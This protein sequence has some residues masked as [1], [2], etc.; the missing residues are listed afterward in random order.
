[1]ASVRGHRAAESPSPIM[2]FDLDSKLKGFRSH[3]F[4]QVAH[5]P[6]R[7]S[8]AFR[9]DRSV[10][11]EMA[12]VLVSVG[13]SICLS[14]KP[15]SFTNPPPERSGIDIVVSASWQNAK[16]AQ[17]PVADLC[18]HPLFIARLA[19][20]TGLRAEHVT[21]NRHEEFRTL[22]EDSM[23]RERAFPIGKQRKQSVF[24]LCHFDP[25]NVFARAKLLEVR[26]GGRIDPLDD[27]G[28]IDRG[29]QLHP[30]DSYVSVE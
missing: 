13:C 16:Q 19:P 11:D 26:C 21:E 15:P 14:C 17:Y 8:L 27:D 29:N 10:R 3:F 7:P 20:L 22:R 4:N 18:P 23:Q 6:V 12:D 30:P 2:V 25:W 9:I 24:A 5:G 28:V 1:M